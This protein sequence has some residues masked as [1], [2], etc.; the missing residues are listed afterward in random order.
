MTLTPES[1]AALAAY[2]RASYNFGT[3]QE[4]GISDEAVTDAF[5]AREEALATLR[6]RIDGLEKERDEANRDRGNSLKI[7]NMNHAQWERAEARL[8]ASDARADE[9]QGLC[10]R[11]AVALAAAQAEIV[12]KTNKR[13]AATTYD[14]TTQPFDEPF[15]HADEVVIA[16][17]HYEALLVDHQRAIAAEAEIVRLREGLAPFAAEANKWSESVPDNYRPKCTEPGS[18]TAHPGSQTAYRLKD[19]RRARSLLTPETRNA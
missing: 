6:A 17:N 8:A 9:L 10:D 3:A 19:L 4:Q 5:D 14:P 2:G 13:A 12:G 11:Q 1:E 16:R 15:R 18:K 7:A